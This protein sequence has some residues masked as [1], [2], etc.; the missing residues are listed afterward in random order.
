MALRRTNSFVVTL[1]VDGEP[2]K[3]R[4]ARMKT[5]REWSDFLG[6]FNRL[7]RVHD[8]AKL[9]L[10]RRPGDEALSDDQVRTKRWA[11]LP[12]DARAKQLLEERE[13]NDRGDAFAKD[14]IEKYVTAELGEIFGESNT[15]IVTGE[16]IVEEFA[17]DR[18]VLSG[19]VT[20]VFLEHSLSDG[21]KKTLR[22][23]LA[24]KPG[25]AS[26][27][28]APGATPAPTAAS[29]GSEASA[30]AAA[31]SVDPGPSPS[32]TTAS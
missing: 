17:A 12:A 2:V 3:F 10:D 5:Q 15:P 18:D 13:E 22:S 29:A 20:H 16:Q 9:L 19:L 32:G 26:A 23:R 1:T 8:G 31:A 11:E 27:A 14:V 30:S 4:I 25:S 28:E 21:Q 24:L 7:G 6:E